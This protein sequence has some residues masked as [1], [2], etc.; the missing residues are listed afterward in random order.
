MAINLLSDR[1]IQSCKPR[2][3]EYL[4]SDGG[5]L[6]LRV[7]PNDKKDWLFIYSFDGKRKKVG[8]GALIQTSLAT[9][10]ELASGHRDTLA[11]EIDPLQAMQARKDQLRHE[12]AAA[13]SR[14]TLKKLFELWL[15][16]ELT[17]RRDRGAEVER[18][19]RKDVLPKMGDLTA[20]EITRPMIAD[21]LD[22]IVE[23]G[24]PIVAR[25]LL[26]DLRQM[27]GFGIKRGYVE[28]DPTSHLKR[29][30]F[31][32][33]LERER[34]LAPAEIRLLGER[35]PNARMWD[36]SV[37]AIWLMLA[38]CCRVG[39]IAAARIEHLDLEAGTWT[40]PADHAKNAKTHV[41]YLSDYARRHFNELKTRAERLG[42]EWLCP[43]KNKQGAHVCPKSLAK[44]IGDRQRPSAKPM[45]GRS[46]YTD[47]LV[48]MN[49]KW[50][51]HDLR[52]T[53]ATLMGELGVRPDVIE[54][55]LNHVQQNRLVRIYQRQEL[56]EQ[57]REAWQ[58]LGTHLESL[59]TAQIGHF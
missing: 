28:H 2:D 29:D 4:L 38:T 53:G 7:R 9:A 5:G 16:L 11:R 57:Q 44:Q 59:T 13:E 52:R 49:G 47:A 45:R 26:G 17:T 30:D 18:C 14:I 36:S 55:C 24:A 48:L 1:K 37:A 23:R 25:N 6:Y 56:R 43:A 27:F 22:K 58:L 20:S 19:F 34:V 31:G 35:L 46:P 21:M 33:K 51:P 41:I 8:L 50:T 40:I 54:K 15:K 12:R 10:R 32:R 3:K 42:S 39:E